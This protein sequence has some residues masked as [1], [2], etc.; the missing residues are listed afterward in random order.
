MAKEPTSSPSGQDAGKQSETETLKAENA[1]LQGKL[2]T[3]GQDLAKAQGQ[4]EAMQPFVQFGRTPAAQPAQQ[5]PTYDPDNPDEVRQH[6]INS[7]VSASEARSNAKFQ[8][9][10]FISD[11]PDLKPHSDMVAANLRKTDSSLPMSTRLSQAG[12]LTRQAIK[13]I[14]DAAVA[15]HTTAQEASEKVAAAAQAGA[16]AHDAAPE[17]DAENTET[18]IQYAERRKTESNALNL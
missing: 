5:A 10:E 1:T 8:S 16:G 4:I 18:D 7:A 3:Q 14:Q 12:E 11:N 6:E 9:L 17:A 15:N 13:T 2:S